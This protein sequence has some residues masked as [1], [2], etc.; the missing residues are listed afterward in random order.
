MTFGGGMDKDMFVLCAV[1]SFG[2]WMALVI[3]SVNL[4]LQAIRP[5][6]Q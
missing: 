5:K 2:I 1:T 3:L 4:L 6:K